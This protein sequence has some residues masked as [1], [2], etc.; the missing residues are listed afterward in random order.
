MKAYVLWDG[1]AI[2]QRGKLSLTE[3]GEPRKQ[4]CA[5]EERTSRSR[6]KNDESYDLNLGEMLVCACL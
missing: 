3:E 1:I 2:L 6:E 4:K 5:C